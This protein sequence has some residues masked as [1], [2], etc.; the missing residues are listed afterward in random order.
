MKIDSIFNSQSIIITL[1]VNLLLFDQIEHL[2]QSGYSVVEINNIDTFML[3]RALTK[4]SDLTIGVGNVIH[5]QQL[6]NAYQ[7]GAHF[8][9]SPGILPALVQMAQ[10]YSINYIPGVSTLS[11]AML[12]SELNCHHVRPFPATLSFCTLLNKYL[13][14]LHLFPAEIEWHEARNFL[15][16]PAV[17]AVSLINPEMRVLETI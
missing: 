10:I 5:A 6:E 9:T 8:A 12:A 16:L 7:V 2:A 1:D 11:E 14:L 13:P 15:K 3:E 17:T 4:F